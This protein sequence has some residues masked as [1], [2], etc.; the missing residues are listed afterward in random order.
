ME[1]N[2]K[3]SCDSADLQYLCFDLLPLNLNLKIKPLEQI[4]SKCV[5]D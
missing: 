3:K 1:K 5:A 2:G 4:S